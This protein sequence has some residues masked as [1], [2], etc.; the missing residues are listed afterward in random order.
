ML[1][2]AFNDEK[3]VFCHGRGLL[4]EVLFDRETAGYALDYL[5]GKRALLVRNQLNQMEPY[6]I[7]TVPTRRE[8][9]YQ[10]AVAPRKLMVCQ[11]MVIFD[12][13]QVPSDLSYI[14]IVP[15]SKRSP[16][17]MFV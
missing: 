2:Q 9:L 15:R 13:E 10:E 11:T 5:D 1:T 7:V 6:E 3:L 12:G 17:L 4:A 16:F 8:F 14:K